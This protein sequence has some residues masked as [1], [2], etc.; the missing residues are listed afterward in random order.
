IKVMLKPH[1]DAVNGQWRGDFNPT[2][3]DAWFQSYTQ[4]IVQYAQLAQ[5]EGVEGLVMGTEFKTIS[6]AA[7]RDR[8]VAVINAIRA[9]YGGVLT[10]AANATFPADEFTSVSFWD[11]LDIIGLDGYFN[12]TASNNPTVNDLIA[13]WTSNR[14]G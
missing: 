1:V 2:N 14:F 12:L 3:A 10:Y 8:W 4:F 13:A 9:V 11:Q 6:G 5:A 7:N